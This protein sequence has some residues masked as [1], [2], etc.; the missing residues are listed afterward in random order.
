MDSLSYGYLI[1]FDGEMY[2]TRYVTPNHYCHYFSSRN[3][4]V[5]QY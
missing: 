4:A 3:I 5:K 2:A 1:F